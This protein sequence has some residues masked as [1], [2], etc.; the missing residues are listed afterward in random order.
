ML[1]FTWDI[2]AF[3]QFV[4]Y[5][6]NIF[7]KIRENFTVGGFRE[8]RSGYTIKHNYFLPYLE[9]YRNVISLICESLCIVG[10]G[11]V[12]GSFSPE[13]CLRPLVFCLKTVS[14][15]KI[16]TS[17]NSLYQKSA[18]GHD[19]Y[20]AFAFIYIRKVPMEVFEVFNTSQG[21]LQM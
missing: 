12:R 13:K 7:W 11:W 14:F 9:Y 19:Y 2:F 4:D 10:S 16:C 6:V 5:F 20:H 15:S 1:L 3:Y 21:T 8:G 17:G 18:Y